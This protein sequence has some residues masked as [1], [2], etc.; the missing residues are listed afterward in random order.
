MEIIFS[1]LAAKSPA[2][3]WALYADWA[4]IKHFLGVLLFLAFSPLFDQT[5]YSGFGIMSR[6]LLTCSLTRV[7]RVA[8]FCSTVCCSLRFSGMRCQWLL[9]QN[10]RHHRIV[11]GVQRCGMLDVAL[12][13]AAARCCHPKTHNVIP[14][15]VVC[16][17]QVLPPC[18]PGC[19]AARFPPPPEDWWTMVKVGFTTLRGNG[20]C[21]D[22]LFRYVCARAHM[23]GGW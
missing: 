4:N 11:A 9:F 21:N 23:W 2:A 6:A 8:S 18:W 14:I 5:P 20:G 22:L 7:L 19:Y 17:P 15:S 13:A 16:C 3:R 1:G 10:V 12:T